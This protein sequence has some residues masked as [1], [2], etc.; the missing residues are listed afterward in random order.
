MPDMARKD[1]DPELG[2]QIRD[3]VRAGLQAGMDQLRSEMAQLTTDMAGLQE[4]LRKDLADLPG[5]MGRVV[6]EAA[7]LRALAH[8]LRRRLLDVLHVDGPA[9]ASVLAEATDQAV[10][11][12]SH[13]LKVLHEAGFIEEAPELAKDRR[14]RWWRSAR[15]SWSWSQSQVDEGAAGAAIARSTSALEI[16]RQFDKALAWL[17]APADVRAHW[18]D[19]DFVTSSWLML[20]PEELAEFGDEVVALVRRWSERTVATRSGRESVFFFAHAVPGRP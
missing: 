6:T 5:G 1:D 19:A 2:A 20:T 10:G 14:E 9:T 17:D 11:N 7:A 4:D 12:V 16:Q 13:H 8:P 18:A 15:R 3:E